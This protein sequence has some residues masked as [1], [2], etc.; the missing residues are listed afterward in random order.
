M[1]MKRIGGV[2]VAPVPSE[3]LVCDLG[4]EAPDGALVDLVVD[5][6]ELLFLCTA[7]EKRL[8]STMLELD[9]LTDVLATAIETPASGLSP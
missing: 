1:A 4:A 7:A 3:L 5:L 2:A 9:P 6:D 8:A